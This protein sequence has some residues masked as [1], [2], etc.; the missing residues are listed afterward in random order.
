MSLEQII[1]QKLTEAFAPTE[2]SV[3]NESHHHEGHGGHSG[4]G[5][6]HWRI[7]ITADIFAGKN[8]VDRQR[9]VNEVLAEEL[10]GTIHAL[11]MT[12]KAPGE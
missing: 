10:K 9:M 1:S 12:V 6:S 3:E 4:S 11:A 8:R 5:D 2:L 7:K